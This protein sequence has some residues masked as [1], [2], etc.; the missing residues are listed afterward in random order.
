MKDSRSFRRHDAS[1]YAEVY[2]SQ[3]G[4]Y[5]G[6]VENVSVSGLRI[7]GGTPLEA[8]TTCEL[9]F[10]CPESDERSPYRVNQVRGVIAWCDTAG[11]EFSDSH[12]ET[13][14]S[15]LESVEQ[16]NRLVNMLC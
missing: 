2:D 11:E 14:V 1:L 10:S 5:L 7:R 16:G 4:D 8:G 9:G 13:G 15:L 6:R 3:T 12:F